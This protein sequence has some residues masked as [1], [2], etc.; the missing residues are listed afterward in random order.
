MTFSRLFM[1]L[2]L[3]CSLLL[4]WLPAVTL[5]DVSHQAEA[6]TL[7][8]LGLFKGSSSGFEL[9]KK[10][11]RAE[12][13]V[14]LVRL[15]GKETQAR[16]QNY[17]HP[18]VDV[19]AWASPYVGYMYKFSL[20]Q[21][22]SPTT[23]SPNQVLSAPAYTTFVLRALGYSDQNGDF[24][25]TDSLNKARDLG[26]LSPLEA[27]ALANSAFLRDDMVNL[28]YH[29]LQITLKNR[30]TSLLE[31]LVSEDHAVPLST[32]QASG[33]L[34]QKSA[35]SRVSLS[36]KSAPDSNTEYTVNN[37][38]DLQNALQQALLNLQPRI[39]LYTKD[40]P[41]DPT[42]DFEQLMDKTILK[43]EEETGL[44]N[45][46]K[47]WRYQGTSKVL[48]V[49]FSFLYNRSQLTE[50][51][52]KCDEVLES[53]LVNSQND[54][55]KE[56][57]IHDYIITHCR[58]DY[59][60]FQK[61]TL[62]AASRTAYGVIVM[63]SGVCQGYAE[64]FNILCRK[65]GLPSL[66]IIGRAFGEDHAWNL[67]RLAGRYYQTDV[68]ADDPLNENGTDSLSY[69]Y[70]NLSDQ[71]MQND[72]Q[73]DRGEYPACGSM[74]YNYHVLNNL[75]VDDY[76]DFADY[77][78]NALARQDETI[79]LRIKNFDPNDYNQLDNL[80]FKDNAASR[81]HYSINEEQGVVNIFS[82]EYR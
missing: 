12:G 69:T 7:N 64:A 3:T 47:G 1:F 63:G 5:A 48:S 36:P 79:D 38:A 24:Q 74:Q 60:N 33:L 20:T 59:Q 15:L 11:T 76:V 46:I 22:S 81:F 42:D 6:Q 57:L 16:S 32:A 65:A 21:G 19:P 78:A 44:F 80:V 40:Y 35:I 62:P 41:G 58:Y 34:H 53:L 55:D 18:F 56:K 45:L 73:W 23:Y 67:I 27:G 43:I 31:K 25:W 8:N 37:S 51:D 61:N 68:T 82:L 9:D 10:P 77:V 2:I 29:A 66:I 39:I 50:L 71:E 4:F 72:H 14:M 13:A 30:D 28:S 17:H 75:Y 26:M 54:Y 49:E 52:I 70:F